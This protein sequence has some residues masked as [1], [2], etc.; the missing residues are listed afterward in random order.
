MLKKLKKGMQ[1]GFLPVFKSIILSNIIYIQLRTCHLLQSLT[2]TTED[3]KEINTL[4]AFLGAGTWN[5]SQAEVNNAG[6]IVPS[7]YARWQ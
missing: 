7:S 3:I 6:F 2:S 5:L 1:C 4:P